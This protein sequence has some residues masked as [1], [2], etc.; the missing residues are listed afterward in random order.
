M[1]NH[2]VSQLLLRLPGLREE[3]LPAQVNAMSDF[4]LSWQAAPRNLPGPT[5][6]LNQLI[7]EPRGVLL[8]IQQG[9]QSMSDGI[10]QLIAAL[11]C[12]NTVVQVSSLP[13]DISDLLQKAGLGSVY[14]RIA[15][16]S[17]L[18]LQSLLLAGEIQGVAISGPH[19]LVR[20]VDGVLASRK[21]ALR[22]LIVETN[23]PALIHRFVL[24][25][26]ISNNTT[27]SGGNASLLA[28]EDS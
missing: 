18:K 23:G 8:C 14:S 9:P 26:A 4:V 15:L 10:R 25:K 2:L 21:G 27:A 16:Q 1:I 7:L 3:A 5:G 6:E 12:G 17:G 24:E 20:W 11:L 28:M 13:V 19:C 22:P